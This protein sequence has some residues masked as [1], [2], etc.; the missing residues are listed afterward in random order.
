MSKPPAKPK[1]LHYFIPP[2]CRG[3]KHLGHER[4]PLCHRLT[5][6]QVDLDHLDWRGNIKWLR[7][8]KP[9]W[10]L[11]A[12]NKQ[13]SKCYKRKPWFMFWRG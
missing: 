6:K 10:Q 4:D 1:E 9:I 8:H 5:F 2:V 11:P 3:C 13:T 7:I 12:K